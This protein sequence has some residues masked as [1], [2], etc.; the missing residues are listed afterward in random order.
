MSVARE[1]RRLPDMFPIITYTPLF[2][3]NTSTTDRKSVYSMLQ[4][5]K[6]LFHTTRH[7][8]R[9][10]QKYKLVEPSHL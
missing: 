3:S 7:V 4:I 1:V 2:G 10:V 8:Y 9:V 5:Q 6:V